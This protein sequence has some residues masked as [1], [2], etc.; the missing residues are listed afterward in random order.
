MSYRRPDLKGAPDGLHFT[1]QGYRKLGERYA[2]KMLELMGIPAEVSIVP[3][4]MRLTYNEPAKAWVEALPI[5][6]SKMG[7][8]IRRSAA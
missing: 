2:L 6:N 8:D 4:D 5:G 3:G 1:A 7:L